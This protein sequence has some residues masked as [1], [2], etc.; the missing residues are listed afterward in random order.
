MSNLK[1]ICREHACLGRSDI[2]EIYSLVRKFRA[3]TKKLAKVM[4]RKTVVVTGGMLR[5]GLS[6]GMAYLCGGAL[7][8][9][10]ALGKRRRSRLWRH[11]GL[12]PEGKTQTP[13]LLL[14]NTRQVTLSHTHR[15]IR[16]PHFPPCRHAGLYLSTALFRSPPFPFLPFVQYAVQQYP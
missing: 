11:C 10:W 6:Q 3:E 7:G 8:S 9:G 13:Q 16:C 2:K 5:S 12:N 14:P 4:G 15:P 1:R